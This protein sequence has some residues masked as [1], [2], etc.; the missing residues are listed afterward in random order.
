MET[1]SNEDFCFGM[2]FNYN[3]FTSDIVGELRGDKRE[4]ILQN[5]EQLV[6]VEVGLREYKREKLIC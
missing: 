4:A 6:G 1:Y 2:K 3:D 5:D